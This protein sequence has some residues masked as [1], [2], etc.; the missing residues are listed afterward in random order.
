MFQP[1]CFTPP[2]SRFESNFMR[3]TMRLWQIS[4]LLVC[5]MM[6]VGSAAA[7]YNLTTPVGTVNEPIG[8]KSSVQTAT[9]TVTSGG[10]L[11]G[12]EVLTEGIN[13][14][15]F[16][17]SSY[18]CNPGAN[19]SAGEVCTIGYTFQ[20]T[21]AG[22]RR[23]GIKL[24][25]SNGNPLG[26]AYIEG[27]GTG[28]QLVTYAATAGLVTP[29]LVIPG[30]I[31]YQW[32]MDGAGNI[33]YS[34]VTQYDQA[35]I[36]KATLNTNGSYTSTLI[37]G[38]LTGVA[39]E[40]GIALDG[41]G[42]VFFQDAFVHQDYGVTCMIGKLTPNNNGY[43]MSDPIS[44]QEGITCGT[45][46]AVDGAGTIF[47]NDN[48]Q[49]V[50]ATETYNNNGSYT[51]ANIAN[52][53]NIA[54]RDI[55]LD[56]ERNVYVAECDAGSAGEFIPRNTDGTYGTP[57]ANPYTNTPQFI[58]GVY[59]DS[60]GSFWQGGQVNGVDDAL[61][62]YVSE[63]GN[64]EYTQGIQFST[65]VPGVVF[66]SVRLDSKGDIFFDGDGGQGAQ[67]IYKMSVSP[68]IAYPSTTA[69]TASAA[70]EVL[71]TNLGTS[72]LTG[73]LGTFGFPSYV[74]QVSSNGANGY[75]DCT[76]SLSLTPG[77]SC[78]LSTEFTPPVDTQGLDSGYIYINTN[79]LNPSYLA[80]TNDIP[81]MGT[82]IYPPPTVTGIS[83][84][85]GDPGI[86]VTIAGTNL[87]Q[88]TA[89]HF[90]AVGAPGLTE[91]SQTQVAAVAPSGTAGSTATISVTNPGGSGSS[92]TP[93]WQYN[94][95][96]NAN[97]SSFTLSP[98]T[99]TQGSSSNASSYVVSSSSNQPLANYVVS[100]V[101]SNTNVATVPGTGITGSQGTASF[102]IQGLFPGTATLT[103]TVDGVTIGRPQILTVSP[104][105]VAVGSSVTGLQ[106]NV[107]ITRTGTLSSILL[108][109]KGTN[110]ADY[111]LSAYYARLRIAS[112]RWLRA[113][114][115]DRSCW[116]T[117]AAMCWAK[118]FCRGSAWDRRDCLA[119]A[120]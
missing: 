54:T 96:P 32:A 35:E 20:P 58:C 75:S 23:G 57:L 21:L 25:D 118:P 119:T 112:V 53:N 6:A 60:S 83:P 111:G 95:L 38:P 40:L 1:S 9:V 91:I 55:V 109:N 14:L 48:Q 19:L 86:P 69:G 66:G 115:K 120:H 116:K 103:A 108:L 5:L 107:K 2:D 92:S 76:S 45:Q 93:L 43:T 110:S 29:Q 82:A 28:A 10:N 33:Y 31:T 79:S 51:L 13:N 46:F 84:T 114:G 47:Y 113:F 81:V 68:S 27:F 77:A 30:N 59:A 63:Y 12:I 97:S 73:A 94:P 87:L 78:L 7:Q 85:F 106:A 105:S 100:V 98:S 11:S 4:A 37:G 16:Q 34:G 56:P 44:E 89:V 49:A 18:N 24:N 15:D 41:L 42:N 64:Y 99:V 104:P 88:A 22:L 62:R 50:I 61:L 67:G 74:T 71:L 72:T 90:N 101:N 117:V 52:T 39:S 8:S 26:I 3:P 65:I 17:L 70:Q 102:P 36:F 80:T